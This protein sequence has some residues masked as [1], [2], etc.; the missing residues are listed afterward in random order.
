MTNM[1]T[2]SQDE[3]AKMAR[4]YMRGGM[5]P[6]QAAR[7]T[8]FCRV[9]LMQEAIRAMEGREALV[10]AS[11][12]A[13]TKYGPGQAT[14]EEAVAEKPVERAADEDISLPED[15]AEELCEDD[16]PETPQTVYPFLKPG[17]VKTAGIL[18]TLLT[19]RLMIRLYEKNGRQLFQ[20][21]ER[22]TGHYLELPQQV[23]RELKTALGLCLG[24]MNMKGGSEPD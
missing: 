22:R 6:Y 23:V 20:V 24:A 2:V 9:T 14:V 8:G 21:T 15:I 11:R 16:E 12:D 17:E 3:R 10:A 1:R 7:N 18:M 13:L 19:E 4:A 5:A